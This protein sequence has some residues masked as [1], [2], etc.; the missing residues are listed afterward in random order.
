MPS[1]KNRETANNRITGR[2]KLHSAAAQFSPA[3]YAERPTST[4]NLATCEEAV[5]PKT[6]RIISITPDKPDQIEQSSMLI[7]PILFI[8][9]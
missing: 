4:R 1:A 2:E 6:R 3:G 8:S 9:C 7:Q 5:L